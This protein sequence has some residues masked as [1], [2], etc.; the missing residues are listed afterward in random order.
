MKIAAIDIGSNSVRLM[1]WADG[2]TLYKRLNTTR[3]GEGLIATGV[4]GRDAMRRTAAAVSEF[5]GAALSEGAQRIYAF[6]TAAVRSASN[7]REFVSLVRDVAGVDVDVISGEEEARIGILGAIGFGDGG[8]IDVGGA[9]TEITL[10]RGGKRIYS[11]S[12]NVGTVKLYDACGRDK[13]ALSAYIR[14]AIAEYGGVLANGLAVY[15]IGGTATTM[16][17]VSL[18][19]PVYDPSKTDGFT[20]TLSE[21][22]SLADKILSLSVEQVKAMPGMEPKRADLIG[23]G[24]LLMC[25]VMGMLGID[26]ITV[27][28]KDNLEGYV[29]SKLDHES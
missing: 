14:G 16:A 24:C 1:M 25:E 9:S 15:A 13:S 4:M 27:S 3:L 12:A 22:K 11:H 7:T 5:V 6:A 29:L 21:A 8:I 20:I 10:Q 2:K 28:E 23:G 19:L 18:G 17:S 26:R